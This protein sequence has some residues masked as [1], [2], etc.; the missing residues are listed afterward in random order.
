MHKNRTMKPDEI[1]PRVGR[2][3]L[4]ENDRGLNLIKMYCKDLHKYCNETQL[5]NMLIKIK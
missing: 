3:Q 4:R 5:H 2:W 1:V